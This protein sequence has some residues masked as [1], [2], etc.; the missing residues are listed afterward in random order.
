MGR[1][2]HRSRPIFH[3]FEPFAKA[4]E[5][6]FCRLL[7]GKCRAVL[8]N[9]VVIGLIEIAAFARFVSV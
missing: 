7:H 1:D 6:A 4:A 5:H 3:A 2:R 8:E 9:F